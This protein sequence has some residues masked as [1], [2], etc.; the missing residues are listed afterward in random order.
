MIAQMTTGL[1]PET[2]DDR[3]KYWFAVAICTAITADGNIAPEEIHYMERALSFLDSKEQVDSLVKSV[4][5]L[6][7]PDL[8]RFP[9]EDRDLASKV[10]IELLLVVCSDGV[11]GTREVDFLLKVGKRLGFGPEF[12][13][14]LIR[15]GSEG[16]VWKRKMNQMIRLGSEMPAEFS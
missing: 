8:D 5:D 1:Q 16:I 4:K 9:G 6:K 12:V 7:L 13:R 15:W 3:Q 11:L 2:M 10:F 14:I